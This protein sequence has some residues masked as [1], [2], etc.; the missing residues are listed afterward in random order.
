MIS[1]IMFYS[2]HF[3]FHVLST[4]DYH[5]GFGAHPQYSGWLKKFH[6]SLG[7]LWEGRTNVV[8]LGCC[9]PRGRSIACGIDSALHLRGKCEE[10][11]FFCGLGLK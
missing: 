10:A 7:E 3:A 6:R 4:G 8:Y 1:R 2:I 5:N 9:S 11:S